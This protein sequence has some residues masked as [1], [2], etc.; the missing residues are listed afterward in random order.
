MLKTWHLYLGPQFS[1]SN[2]LH[3]MYKLCNDF[4]VSNHFFKSVISLF[5][6]SSSASKAISFILDSDQGP[7]GTE[8]S[9]F[10]PLS[11]IAYIQSPSRLA[12]FFSFLVWF[13]ILQE[14][15]FLGFSSVKLPWHY[16]YSLLLW[17]DKLRWISFI[18]LLAF[19]V[20]V[21]NASEMLFCLV[22]ELRVVVA[23]N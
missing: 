2:H 5:A 17:R 18:C 23:V 11:S 1:S 19:A 15:L 13:L 14:K 9:F 4:L 6:C 8:L 12:Q 3:P 7:V 21:G 22:F 20:K 16:F 10:Q